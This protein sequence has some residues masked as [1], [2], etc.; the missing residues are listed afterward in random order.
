[1]NI[2]SVK[3][4]NMELTP[5]IK[6]YLEDKLA[7]IDAIVGDFEPVADVDIDVG[8]ESL[9]HNKGPYYYAEFTMHV[10]NEVL[11]ARETAEDLYEAIDIARDQLR[12]QIVDFK[13]KLQD[14]SQKAQRPDK[15]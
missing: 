14:R 2:L 11:R 3:G 6:A 15:A 1:M 4:T 9:H 12:R 8:K 7:A 5:A 13:G 10:P